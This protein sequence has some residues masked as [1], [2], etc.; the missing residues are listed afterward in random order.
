MSYN[1]WDRNT[2]LSGPGE[3][4]L[5]Q[6]EGDEEGV[7]DSHLKGKG[8]PGEALK[9]Q[10]SLSHCRGTCPPFL[11]YGGVLSKN[12]FPRKTNKR[13]LVL[14]RKGECLQVLDSLVPFLLLV[15]LE[16]DTGWVEMSDFS[17]LVFTEAKTRWTA[18]LLMWVCNMC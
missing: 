13:A 17:A 6:R 15:S 2:L 9:E 12:A 5:N 7:E 8:H 10:P 18:G 1:L 11:I 14:D 3:E 16:G 4:L